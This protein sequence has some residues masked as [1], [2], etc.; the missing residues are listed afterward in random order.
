MTEWAQDELTPPRRPLPRPE[1]RR[2]PVVCNSRSTGPGATPYATFG[3]AAA[4]RVT[5]V[6]SP[7]GIVGFQYDKLSRRTSMTQ[8]ATGGPARTTSYGYE[9]PSGDLLTVTDWTSQATTF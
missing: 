7:Q 1:A 9:S 4:G 2:A 3:Y 8:T 5:Q 6:A